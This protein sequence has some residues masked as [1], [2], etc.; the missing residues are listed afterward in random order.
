MTHVL[1]PHPGSPSTIVQGI[2]VQYEWTGPN[3]LWLRYFVDAPVDDLVLPDP[4]DNAR[5]D[6][7]SQKTCLELFLREPEAASYLEFNFSPSSNWAAYAFTAYRESR[8]DIALPAN[9]EIALDAGDTFF[10]LEVDLTLPRS[11]MRPQ[12]VAALS[13]VVIDTRDVTS[14]WALAHRPGKPDFHHP[15][16]FALELAPPPRG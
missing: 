6:K 8:R 15:D 9:P 7:L 2:E 14:Y 16:C 13:A 3:A 5:I 1:T 12:L 4:G 11:A 10:A